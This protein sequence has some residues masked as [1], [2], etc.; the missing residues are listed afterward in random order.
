MEPDNIQN[1]KV[2]EFSSLHHNGQMLVLPNIWNPFG[3]K[4]LQQSGYKAV[5]T[6]S[7]AVSLSNGFR[8]GQNFP[9]DELLLLLKRIVKAVSIPVSADIES[10]YATDN[11]TLSENVKKLI[12]TGIAGINFEDSVHGVN[13]LISKEKQAEKI[14][15]IRR[16]ADDSGA[17]LFINARSDVF[18]KNQNHSNQEKTNEIVSR[19]MLYKDA[20]ADG[21]YPIF[22][23]DE[24]IIRI[25]IKEVGLPVNLL[26]L[27]GIPGLDTLKSIGVARVSLG[28]GLF[29]FA[30]KAMKEISEKLLNYEGMEEIMSNPITSDFMNEL[31]SG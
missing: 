16:I 6:A 9:F 29:K 18:L 31:I 15:M 5:A 7:A 24:A 30:V 4:L 22:L 2:K 8:D 19:G 20:G 10:G 23:K 12:D 11:E 25:I 21:F 1:K 27:P 17:G 26:M 13:G 3:A 14:N 28:P